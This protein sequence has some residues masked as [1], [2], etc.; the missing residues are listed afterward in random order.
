[1][2]IITSINEVSVAS[3]KL[4]T[5][6]GDTYGDKLTNLDNKSVK[7]SSNFSLATSFVGKAIASLALLAPAF[8]GMSEAGAANN[9]E[10]EKQVV[11]LAQE[12]WKPLREALDARKKVEE[13]VPNS[14][15]LW[16][17][18][19]AVFHVTDD[20]MVKDINSLRL[21]ILKR[22]TNDPSVPP[23]IVHSAMYT[24]GV[25]ARSINESIS[26]GE[27]QLLELKKEQE[28]LQK[29][30][31]EITNLKAEVP[32]DLKA[33]VKDLESR[34]SALQTETSEFKQ[35]LN[36]ASAYLLPYMGKVIVDTKTKDGLSERH[37]VKPADVSYLTQG[38]ASSKVYYPKNFDK[39][40]GYVLAQLNEGDITKRI[41]DELFASG[42]D[43]V[44]RRE[45]FDFFFNSN[46]AT[47]PQ[48]IRE[49]SQEWIFGKDQIDTVRGKKKEENKSPATIVIAPAPDSASGK[50]SEKDAKSGTLQQPSLPPGSITIQLPP[51][52][53]IQQAQPTTPGVP[54]GVSVGSLEQLTE[55]DKRLTAI[56]LP[57]Y[58]SKDASEQQFIADNTFMLTQGKDMLTVKVDGKEQKIET[59]LIA[60]A[61]WFA[62]KG[63][64]ETTSREFT[65]A[66][67]TMLRSLAVMAQDNKLAFEVLK[68]TLGSFPDLYANA[69]L[70]GTFYLWDRPDR[71]AGV[72]VI[73]AFNANKE[74]AKEFLVQLADRKAPLLWKEPTNDSDIKSIDE[75]RET[76][77]GFAL[78]TMAHLDGSHSFVPY[79]RNIVNNPFAKDTDRLRAII[80]VA[81]ARDSESIDILLKA[82][83]DETQNEWTRALC[84]EAVLYID[85]PDLVPESI[86]QKAAAESPF[87]ASKLHYA[88]PVRGKLTSSGSEKSAREIISLIEK[89]GPFKSRIRTLF[90]T[91]LEEQTRLANSQAQKGRGPA[92]ITDLQKLEVLM[93]LRKQEF[94][95][96]RGLLTNKANTNA[97]FRT[98]LDGMVRYLE[99]CKEKNRQISL[100]L[101]LP[102]MDILAK[103]RD[104]KASN[105]LV[106]MATYPEQYVRANPDAEDF[107]AFFD[108]FRTA[109]YSTILKWVAIEDLGG[110]CNLSDSNDKASQLIHTIARKDTSR[111]YRMGSQTALKILA[112]RYDEYQRNPH[113]LGPEDLKIQAA[114]KHHAE[115]ALGHMKYHALGLEDIG[116]MRYY[117]LD[118]EYGWA[119]IVDRLGGTKDLL[120]YALEKTKDNPNPQVLR[121]AMHALRG[122]GKKVEDI[123][124]LGFEPKVAEKL[125]ELY[126][127]VNRQE[128]WL[129]DNH[130][131]HTGKGVDVAVLDAGYVYPLEKL[132]PGIEKKIIYPEKMI[133]W[134]DMTE[135]LDLHPSMVAGT[136]YQM[137]P[138]PTIRSYSFLAS[139]PEVPFRPFE[140]QNSAIYA[141]EDMAQMQIEGKANI[142]VVNYS[143]GYINFILANENLRNEI[144]DLLGAFMEVNSKMGTLHTVA[145]GNENGLF[146]GIVRWANQGEL[147]TTGLRYDNSGKASRPDNVF[148]AGAMDGYAKMLAEFSSV[149]DPLR[150][151]E[152]IQLLSFQGVHVMAPHIQDREWV[153]HPV[154]GTSFAAPSEAFLLSWGKSARRAAGLPELSAKEWQQVLDKTANKRLPHR[155]DWEGG[156]Y[157]DVTAYLQEVLRPQQAQAPQ[158]QPAIANKKE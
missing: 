53:V 130:K 157:L 134:S 90:N 97:T 6:N 82:A 11:A 113:T 86:R 76:G 96:S 58:S 1:M 45:F 147:N 30:A 61:Q 28:V 42:N 62:L 47:L 128:Y 16:N 70:K 144:V 57:Y 102:M 119:K 50:T 44:R 27:K 35:R 46:P 43:T 34:I 92:T 24:M 115:Q 39:L 129:G 156:R 84:M 37:L 99:S 54:K 66:D 91:W 140:V 105:V 154:N 89:A 3:N 48:G 2:P 94:S 10:K 142:D 109:I 143:W 69:Y 123:A 52:T 155:E 59:G 26:Q 33:K 18:L 20:T 41:T 83:M 120:S 121:S 49:K 73:K 114:R 100:D 148:M 7:K 5:Q 51:G 150:T 124:K 23:R 87:S 29:K 25:Y 4:H 149:N 60:S 106:D 153:L 111:I 68:R 95:G 74:S 80:G 118:D 22:G 17:N 125:A 13:A 108:L 64:S 78:I 32:E 103:A 81:L 85:T 152:A 131:K 79:M 88:Y 101:A 93:E 151:F 8:W 107:F 145:A 126:N 36:G 77:R 122:N 12:S 112:D 141:L 135:W 127:H 14:N 110:T 19:Q 15:S 117:A 38:Y 21:D 116:Q 158:V 146:P 132:L 72:E 55:L 67:Y 31:G 9:P 137:A 40:A 65:A 71:Q 139:I 63:Y 75:A 104:G 133:K 138:D 56:Y 136:F 98:Q